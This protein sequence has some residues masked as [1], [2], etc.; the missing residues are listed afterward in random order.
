MTYVLD[1]EIAPILAVLAERSAGAPVPLRGDWRALRESGTAGQTYLAG[2][3]PKVSGVRAETFYATAADGTSLELR[4]YTKKNSDPGSAVLY[5]HGGGMIMGS[6]NTY[7]ELLSWYVHQTGVPFLA[8]QYRL[9][10][11]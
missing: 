8:V 1:P 2:L 6:L 10:P 5:A 4:W 9:A 11:E 3:V 7:D